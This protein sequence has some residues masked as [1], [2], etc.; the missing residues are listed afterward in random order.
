MAA[1]TIIPA[2]FSL[3]VGEIV[4]ASF[5][6]GVLVPSSDPFLAR[7]IKSR[8]MLLSCYSV[9][10]EFLLV[11]RVGA[12]SIRLFLVDKGDMAVPW[13]AGSTDGEMVQSRLALLQSSMPTLLLSSTSNTQYHF[14]HI[15]S[16]LIPILHG[17]Q[18]LSMSSLPCLEPLEEYHMLA[19]DICFSL[20]RPLICA[21]LSHLVTTSRSLDDWFAILSC[22]SQVR[23]QLEF[24]RHSLRLW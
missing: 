20:E 8:P 18:P 9:A 3:A 16:W 19:F 21:W 6:A 1:G 13:M 5:S 7:S 17:G 15:A 10:F 4:Q 24:L 22:C 14:I 2:I 23:L 11:D 12:G